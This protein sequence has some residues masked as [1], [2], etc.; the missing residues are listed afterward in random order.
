MGAPIVG[1]S[2]N[3]RKYAR[4]ERERRFLLDRFPPQAGV[5]RVLRLTDRYIDNANLRLRK[6]EGGSETVFKLTQKIPSSGPGY[7]RGFI[8]TIYIRQA[9]YE[10]LCQLP[11]AVLSKTRHSVPTFGIDVFEDE[12]QGLVLAEVEF[13]TPEEA[14]ALTIP[15]F[16]LFEVTSDE[17][18][19]G[20]CLA[21]ASRRDVKA[22]LAD[23]EI[24]I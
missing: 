2:E 10:L 11:A 18:F 6:Q 13:D 12:L 9:E 14:T 3:Q 16:A 4:I 20:G 8:T 5:F 15:D 24:R 23:Y 1:L 7:Q 17:R 19:D 21:R 22:W